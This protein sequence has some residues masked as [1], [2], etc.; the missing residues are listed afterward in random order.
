MATEEGVVTALSATG[1]WVKTIR[2]SACKHCSSKDSCSSQ[3]GEEALVEA[4]NLVNAKVGDRILVSVETAALLK[5]SFLIYVFPILCLIAGAILGQFAGPRFNLDTAWTSPA[6]GGLFFVASLFFMKSK[7]NRLAET[8]AYKPTIVRILP[9]T[10]LSRDLSSCPT[11][12][13]STR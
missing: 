10:R 12:P 7:G 6:A 9:A 3:G 13:A 5:A 11:P 2:S 8:A 1:A 4:V